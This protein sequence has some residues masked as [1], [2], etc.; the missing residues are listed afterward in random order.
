MLIVPVSMEQPARTLWE[1]IAVTAN[2]VLLDV[3]AKLTSMTATPVK[4]SPYFS[5]LNEHRLNRL[6][7]CF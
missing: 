7:M 4:L 6:N 5:F 2:L 1:A 3:T